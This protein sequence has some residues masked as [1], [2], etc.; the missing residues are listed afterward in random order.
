MSQHAATLMSVSSSSKPATAVFVR[1]RFFA[2]IAWVDLAKAPVD[3]L[4]G[5]VA[6]AVFIEF[7]IPV[8]IPLWIL[9]LAKAC[10]IRQ[11]GHYITIRD[12]YASGATPSGACNHSS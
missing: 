2:I 3:V 12:T 9:V 10:Y 8:T 6:V 11:L 4:V 5:A 1:P 7:G